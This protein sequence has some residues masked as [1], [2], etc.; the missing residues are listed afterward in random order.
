MRVKQGGWLIDDGK[1]EDS[2]C[3]DLSS[4]SNEDRADGAAVDA[5]R[6]DA[7]PVPPSSRLNT[8]DKPAG[9]AFN[10]DVGK[11]KPLRLNPLI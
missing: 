8:L 11:F 3:G 9:M 10:I 2:Y 6:L 4:T 7:N 1:H 5:R